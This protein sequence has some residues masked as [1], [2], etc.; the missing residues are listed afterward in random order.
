VPCHVPRL[1]QLA[2]IWLGSPL[3]DGNGPGT[4]TSTHDAVRG[5]LVR[6][7]VRAA[8]STVTSAQWRQLAERLGV[9]AE[10]VEVDGSSLFCVL[11]P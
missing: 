6:I 1:S 4:A 5:W 10:L 11:R 3:C 9:P 7:V 2:K 8:P